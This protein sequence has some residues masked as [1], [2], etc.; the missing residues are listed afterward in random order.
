MAVVLSGMHINKLSNDADF[1]S[2]CASIKSALNCSKIEINEGNCRNIGIFVGTTFTNFNLREENAQ[3]YF[4][5]GIRVVNPTLF[6]RCL[7]SYLGGHFAAALNIKGCNATFSSGASG[8]LDALT[9]GLYFL[10]RNTNNKALIVELGDTMQDA[11]S[12]TLKESATWLIENS[13]N[14]DKKYADIVGIESS[15]ESKGKNSGLIKAIG[16]ALGRG[17]LDFNA[18]DYVFVSGI[19]NKDKFGLTKNAADHFGANK[20]Q[21]IPFDYPG[22]TNDHGLFFISNVLKNVIS[23]RTKDKPQLAMFVSLGENTNS[24]CLVVEI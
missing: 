18:I 2:V 9:E 3:K 7:I 13:N 15:F 5:S 11:S 22:N 1:D 10:K 20:K 21:Y 16:K 19:N 17:I 4:E 8:G 24:C 12:Y 23:L 6:P 14:K